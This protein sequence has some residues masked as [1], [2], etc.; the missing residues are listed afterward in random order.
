MEHSNRLKGKAYK[1]DI[2]Q[3]FIAIYGIFRTILSVSGNP[4]IAN[5]PMQ[6]YDLDSCV[7][8]KPSNP[9]EGL[10]LKRA[11]EISGGGTA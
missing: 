5:P 8:S 6:I 2:Y 7:I 1:S 4:I 3:Y 11:E 9:I 10:K